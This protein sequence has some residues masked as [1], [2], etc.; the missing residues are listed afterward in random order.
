MTVP[1]T[2]LLIIDDESSVC[3]V[4]RRVLRN[5]VDE[6][7]TAETPVDAHI[8]LKTK[9]VTHVICDHLLGPGQPKG[10]E[11]AKNWKQTYASIKKIVILTGTNAAQT[12]EIPSG[13]DHI[14]PKTTEPVKLVNYLSLNSTPPAKAK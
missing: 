12:I 13:I 7:V 11:I 1:K 8:V 10:L 6:I 4:L 5:K 14:L 3:R 9:P 2:I